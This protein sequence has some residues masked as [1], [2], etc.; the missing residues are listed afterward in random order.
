MS[1]LTLALAAM[2]AALLVPPPLV[3]SWPAVSRDRIE[4]TGSRSSR[5]LVALVAGSAA[6]LMI[7]LD[8]T[9]LALTLVG[10]GVAAGVLSLLARSRHNKSADRRQAKVV[11]TCEALVG[12]LRAGLPPLTSLEHC[13][14]IW[15]D[16]EPVVAAARLGAD[17]PAA[18]HRL[19]LLPGSLG[20]REVAAAWQVSERSGAALSHA[21]DQVAVSA[22]ARQTTRNLVRAELASAQATAR[23]VAVLPFVSLAMAAGVGARP[24]HFLLGTAP[25]VAC[26]GVGACL[27]LLGL[28]WIDRIATAVLLR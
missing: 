14:E 19:S 23:T 20:L 13:L 24:W 11:E 15:P 22:R 3:G 26:L 10:I 21:L 2:S 28:H 6:V 12:E 8:G 7:T 17:V 9:R 4:P 16:L 18:L 1:A 27:A 25:G 5:R